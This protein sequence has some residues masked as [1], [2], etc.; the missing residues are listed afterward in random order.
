MECSEYYEA[1]RMRLLSSRVT[2]TAELVH[3]ICEQRRLAYVERFQ[4]LDSLENADDLKLFTAGSKAD[5][6]VAA[7]DLIDR[8]CRTTER[9]FG[10]TEEER[11]SNRDFLVSLLGSLW[12]PTLQKWLHDGISDRS[13]L[14]R[15][16]ANDTDQSQ[17]TQRHRQFDNW[18]QQLIRKYLGDNFDSAAANFSIDR[19][20]N[21]IEA[22]LAQM[23]APFLAG[24]APG[25]A[26]LIF[27]AI[28]SPLVLP[29]KCSAIYPALNEFPAGLRQ[30]IEQYR[31]RRAGQLALSTYQ[32]LR[33]SRQPGLAKPVYGPSLQE[34][35]FSPVV[36][37]YLSR[38][39]LTF[40]PR[41][42]LG[43]R[44]IV[45]SWN[46]VTEILDRDNDFL[47]GPVNEKRIDAVSG[48][49][50]LG[51][52]RGPDLGRQREQVYS[53][54][55]D[56]D[57]TPFLM[58]IEQESA[59]LLGEAVQ[60]GGRIDVVNGYARLVAARSA[61]ALFGIAGPTEQDL[62]RVARAIFQ[63]TFL[64]QS[65]DPS[66][67][68]L[69][70]KAGK[71]LRR[72]IEQEQ[73]RRCH[74]NQFGTDVLGRLMEQ[75]LNNLE[76]ARWMLAGLFVGAIDTTATAVA[77]IVT[78]VLS[79][80]GLRKAMIN[81]ID[82]KRRLLG[83]CWEA[84]RR[85]PHNVGMLREAANGAT[86]GQQTVNKGTQ[87]VLLTVGA[88]HDPAAFDRPKELRPDRPLDR[89]LHFG[90]GLHQCSGRDFN[91]IQI[92]AL[93]RNL[94]RHGVQGP[95]RVR[96]RGPFPDELIVSIQQ[97]G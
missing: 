85:R 65:N 75:S 90:R 68:Q 56:A 15:I 28:A 37:R 40:A 53:A 42:Q 66:V 25:T 2:P 7:L 32:H 97:P 22:R 38:C 9:V 43:N 79:D 93:V 57:K 47:I 26:D 73:Q 67:T 16:A 72:W 69:G 19:Q 63:E 4:P 55:R 5:G 1:P 41:L 94:L 62:M 70:I 61:A 11:V 31:A 10:E 78:E 60:A 80:S 3:W 81:D 50:I 71:E 49:F 27:A 88:M 74:Q 23:G 84:L 54:L 92:P 64:N 86:I 44:L 21:E 76:A 91:A 89:Y 59:R 35:I 46:D 33:P 18:S 77:N 12:R 48:P 17:S 52:D 34:R 96:T 24:N 20:L 14:L 51:M 45:S 83:W 87:V 82:H 39:L 13:F 30:S 6:V 36:V 29:D 58:Q 95:P 8:R